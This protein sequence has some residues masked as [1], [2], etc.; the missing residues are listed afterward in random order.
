VRGQL[1]GRVGFVA[2]LVAAALLAWVG[3]GHVGLG[4][5]YY[6]AAVRSMLTGPHPFLYG[7]FDP[8]GFVSVDKPP[9]GL[10]LQVVSA[11]LFGFSGP[12]LILPS[13]LACV[14]SV[15]LLGVAVRRANGRSAGLLAAAALAITPVSVVVARDNILDGP[16]VALCL[17][18]ALATLAATRTARPWP[19]LGAALCV[20]LA[21]NV[22]FLEA[23]LVVSALAVA[24]VLGAPGSWR[25]RAGV[26]AASGA[27]L[28][29]VS[30]SW[31]AFVDLTPADQ[32][33][34]VGS[35]RT[36]SA[37]ELA[38]GYDGIE[39]LL[40]RP[41][42]ETETPAPTT[43][44]GASTIPSGEPSTGRL[45]DP[46]PSD[47]GTP[48]MLR[49]LEAQLGGQVGWFLPLTLLGLG[50][51]LARLP[52]GPWRRGRRPPLSLRQ[53]ATLL[54]GGWF[55]TA[56]AFCSLARFISP[57]Y[58]AV[59]APPAAALAG[60]GAVTAWRAFWYPGR[61]GWLLP[62][63]VLATGAEAWTILRGQ[64]D[65]LPWLGPA[66]LVAAVLAA[67][68][69]CLERTA[70]ARSRVPGHASIEPAPA[71]RRPVGRSHRRVVAVVITAAVCAAPALWTLD[72]LR[73]ANEGSHPLAG[74]SRAGD[75][76]AAAPNVGSRL[77]GYLIDHAGS[78]RFLVATLDAGTAAP[79]ILSTGR[80]AMALGGFSGHDPILTAA[81]FA[82]D[83]AT[84]VVR[85]VYLPT[86]DLMPSQQRVLY[87]TLHHAVSH[88]NDGAL[89]RWVV[90]RCTPLAP[91][92]WGPAT[93]HS[94]QALSH[95]LFD[96]G[97]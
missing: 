22:K 88:R 78:S 15:G 3:I 27:V 20:G 69:L 12:A 76:P 68:G 7:S 67:G 35:T 6:A 17:A 51:G 85:Y 19:L 4:N 75:R 80:P 31:L 9:L 46:A 48:G 49:L 24:Y 94:V 43:D 39:R 23:Y 97:S 18:A 90:E 57:Y 70:R 33:P 89:A 93:A 44:T 54:W 87:P 95:E 50:V 96:C 59:I 64:P 16:L 81:A 41:A 47:A 1:V 10:W 55:L 79:F 61:M 84:G 37:F 36:N 8:A 32:R 66:V 40:G 13:A 30:V 92:A 63:V 34:Y 11:A 77:L 60:D 73:A 38:L 25:R 56:A 29:A 86:G 72:S 71:A 5:T 42:T 83:V 28:L 91:S 14:V 53:V 58:L 82:A 62:L 21:F 74:P 26:L 2:P 52:W 45:V 65:W